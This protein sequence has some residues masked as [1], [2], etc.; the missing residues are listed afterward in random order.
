MFDCIFGLIIPMEDVFFIIGS[1]LNVSRQM[2]DL[3]KHEKVQLMQFESFEDLSPTSSDLCPTFILVKFSDSKEKI[4]AVIKEFK[5]GLSTE[6]IFVILSDEEIPRNDQIDFI[7]GGIDGFLL[8][9]E[10]SDWV[11]TYL[12][13]LYRLFMRNTGSQL[14]DEK[15]RLL[16]ETMFS[17]YVSNSRT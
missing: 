13:S 7:N 17:A 9:D 4:L 5:L 6:S 8:K 15:F 3:L 2:Y 12:K 11:L 10:P 16:F 14:K 1:S